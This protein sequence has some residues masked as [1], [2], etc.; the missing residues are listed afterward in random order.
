MRFP[1]HPFPVTTVFRRCVLVNFSSD[2]ATLARALPPPLVPALYADRAW[3]S[4][5]IATMEK[6]RPAFVPRALGISYNQV[7]YRAIVDCE[8]NRGVHFLRS[9]ADSRV[10]TW[11]GNL[12]S[13]FRF[14]RSRVEIGSED[15]SLRVEVRSTEAKADISA[16]FD[17]ASASDRLP[18]TS[19]FGDLAE[20]K[21]WLVELFTAYHPRP[22]RRPIDVVCIDRSDWR[23]TVLPNAGVYRFMDAGD[24]FTPGSA[25]LD[26]VFVV[27]DL[28]YRWH[29]LS[30]IA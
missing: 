23:L 2:P 19:A 10:M 21:R 24:P 6:M 28:K 30:R 13:F 8:G 25:R 15:A 14:H 16:T 1:K 18:S 26:S 29:R 3:V 5:V 9:D 20:A 27:E 4:I 11:L 17:L 22:A 12:M 7:V